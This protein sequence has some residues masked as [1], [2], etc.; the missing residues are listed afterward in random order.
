MTTSKKKYLRWLIPILIIVF[1]C[2]AFLIYTGDY[3]H[4]KPSALD[5]LNSDNDVT[6]TK[7]D[8]GYLFDG[9]SKKDALIFYPGAKVEEEAYAKLLHLLAKEGIDVCL[10]SMPFHLA[11]LDPNKADDVM[12]LYNYENWYIGGHSLGGAMAADYA[13]DNADKLKGVILLAAYPTKQLDKSLLEISIY[14]SKD[15]VLNLDKVKEG[16]QYA[17][18]Q[19][20]EYVIKGSNHAQ[21]GN[22]GAQEGDHNATMTSDMQQQLTVDYI[23]ENIE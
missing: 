17:P 12:K 9:P 20:Y 6:V 16:K 23:I 13:S 22:Y 3:Y 5:A 1:A 10:V 2:S 7:T 14:G 15:G 11:V 4:A 18:N 19:F 21:F 8:Y